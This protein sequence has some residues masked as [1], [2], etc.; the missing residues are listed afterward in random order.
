M[1]SLSLDGFVAALRVMPRAVR[2]A[3]QR[4]L[5]YGAKL[6]ADEARAELGTYQG[7]AGSLP[8]WAR[9][10]EATQEERSRLGYTPDDPGLRSGAMRDSIQQSVQHPVAVVGSND[11]NLVYFEHGTSK[12][13]ARPVLGSAAFRKGEEAANAIGAA[14]ERALA[15]KGET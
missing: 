13:P 3:E 10:A 12:Q 6:I 14:V 15:G 9:L 2:A 11:P 8:A 7:A 5:E 1:K 4:G